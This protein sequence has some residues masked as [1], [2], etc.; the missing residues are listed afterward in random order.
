M[1]PKRVIAGPIMAIAL[2]IMGGLLIWSIAGPLAILDYDASSIAL[3]ESLESIPNVDLCENSSDP[4]IGYR[5]NSCSF[6]YMSEELIQLWFPKEDLIFRLRGE[7][8]RNEL[9]QRIEL[10]KS[11]Q[12]Y[13]QKGFQLDIKELG[14]KYVP[15]QEVIIDMT[16]TG[17]PSEAHSGR[18]PSLVIRLG[19]ANLPWQER[20][21]V[22]PPGDEELKTIAAGEQRKFKFKLSAPDQPGDYSVYAVFD[23]P[24][25]QLRGSP[26]DVSVYSDVKTLRVEE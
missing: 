20:P 10:A 11:K 3:L 1:K 2:I 19:G 25:D 7:A 17:S 14:S 16:L 13:L 8:L 6:Y 12:P 9:I 24:V 18:R 4:G 5:C 26:E 21:V 15:N 23:L 22:E